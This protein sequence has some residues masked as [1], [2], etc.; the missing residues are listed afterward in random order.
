MPENRLALLLDTSTRSGVVLLGDERQN[1]Y[2]TESV[3][4]GQTHGRDL[5]PAIQRL[6]QKS[7]FRFQD[8]DRLA[9]GIGPGSYTGLRV[10]LAVIKT[11]AEVIDCLVLPIDSLLLPV[12]NLP[13]QVLSAV[14]IADAQRGAVYATYYHR[15]SSVD[16]WV[17]SEK[18][19]IVAWADLD[20]WAN[21]PETVVTGPGLLLVQKL[22]PLSAKLANLE[23]SG[24][25][26][27]GLKIWLQKYMP[28]VQPVDRQLLEPLYIRPSAAEEKRKAGLAQSNEEHS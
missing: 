24:P 23:Q 14:S 7:G 5:I 10:G 2:L 3:D 1:L 19:A 22:G 18:P 13:D 11:L 25:G 9:V 8:I 12:L 21:R 27:N 16:N 20:R 17:S 4:P 6:V 28:D 26:V 15:T